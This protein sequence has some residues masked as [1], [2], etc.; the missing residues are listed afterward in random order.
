ML[1]LTNEKL[2]AM[3]AFVEGLSN[4]KLPGDDDPK[5]QQIVADCREELDD[6]ECE[7]EEAVMAAASN[8]WIVS[9]VDDYWEAIKAAR[10]FM[11]RS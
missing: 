9:E 4:V 2:A 6:P 3:L 5:M 1:P 8:D 10:K 7:P 11:G